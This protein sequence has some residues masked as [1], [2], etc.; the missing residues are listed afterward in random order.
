MRQRWRFASS[1]DRD[2]P[3]DT[4]G[5]LCFDQCFE[6]RNVNAA[7]AKWRDQCRERAAEHFFYVFVMSSEVETSLGNS[8][9]RDLI[10]S[11]PVLSTSGLPVYVAA[12][13]VAPFST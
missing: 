7:I 5:N 9:A 10:R 3:G 4:C 11:R 2:N 6:R 13:P 1:T 8:F 12:S